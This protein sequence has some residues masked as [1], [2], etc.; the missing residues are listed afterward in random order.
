M[1]GAEMSRW[2][3]MARA[4]E[5]P[6]VPFANIAKNPEKHEQSR[7]KVNIGNNGKRQTD[8]HRKSPRPAE[9]DENDFRVFYEERAALLEY[10]GEWERADAEGQ[11]FEATVIQWMNITPPQNLDEDH[12]ARCGKPLDRIGQDAVPVLAGGGGH[13]WLHHEC[14]S[15]WVAWRRREAIETLGAMGIS[16]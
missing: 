6:F 11:A 12:C 2:L 15:A 14:H 5:K 10:D 1:G 7:A 8:S 4:V 3:D 13:A 9:W 16:P